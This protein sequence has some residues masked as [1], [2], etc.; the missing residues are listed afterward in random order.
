MKEM[1]KKAK[2]KIKEKFITQAELNDE[3]K[4]EPRRKRKRTI[5]NNSRSLQ[6]LRQQQQPAAKKQKPSAPVKPKMTVCTQC[7]EEFKESEFHVAAFSDHIVVCG[8][9]QPV[10]TSLTK[11]SA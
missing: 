2:S 6:N 4:T 7:H 3:T 10:R 1:D 5:S 8:S 11:A 9:F